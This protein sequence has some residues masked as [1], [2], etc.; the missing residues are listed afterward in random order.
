[1]KKQ[2]LPTMGPAF[3]TAAT[4]SVGTGLC[5]PT[6]VGHFLEKVELLSELSDQ[7]LQACT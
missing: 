6:D 2:G 5:A 1:M 3:Y 4:L 7:S